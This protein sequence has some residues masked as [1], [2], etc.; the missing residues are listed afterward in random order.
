MGVPEHHDP[1][2]FV[3]WTLDSSPTQGSARIAL[4]VAPRRRALPRFRL[5]SR[6]ML[7]VYLNVIEGLP[8]FTILIASPLP[9]LAGSSSLCTVLLATRLRR[10][11]DREPN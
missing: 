9:S 5:A 3:R 2:W 7:L 6:D 11:R 10:A 4:P 8:N 1:Q